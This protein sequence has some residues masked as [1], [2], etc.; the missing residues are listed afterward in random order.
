M[1]Q[2]PLPL[3]EPAPAVRYRIVGPQT[4]ALVREDYLSGVPARV[5]AARYGVGLSNLKRRA[6]EAGW[7]RRD[8][9]ARLEAQR[10][11]PAPASPSSPQIAAGPATEPEPAPDPVEAAAQG[12][13]EAARRLARG[14]GRGALEMLKAAD[15]LIDTEAALLAHREKMEAQLRK[16]LNLARDRQEEAEE[17]QRSQERRR[18]FAREAELAEAE[19][20]ARLAGLRAAALEPEPAQPEAGEP[21]A[22]PAEPPQPPAPVKPKLSFEER[23][24]LASGKS[25]PE[26]RW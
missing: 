24:R 23:V 14:N 1:T 9:A 5:C 6:R 10:F 25:G 17:R 2:T 12:A 22:E 26:S 7:T 8:H 19:H 15:A 3:A 21:Q 4:W 16:E 13:E 20:Q 11:R 18:Q